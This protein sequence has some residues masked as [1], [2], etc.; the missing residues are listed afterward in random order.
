MRAGERQAHAFVGAD[1]DQYRGEALREQLVQVVDAR[2]E[3]QLDAQV[4]DIGDLA[5]DDLG[6]QAIFGHADAQHAAGDGQAPRRP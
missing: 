4:E 5:L 3:A 1:G 2:V 6:R